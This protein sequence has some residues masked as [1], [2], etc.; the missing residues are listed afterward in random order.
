MVNDNKC[1]KC[2]KIVEDDRKL[3]NTPKGFMCI[4]CWT[5]NDVSDYKKQ[6]KKRR[7]E[8]NEF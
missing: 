6:W 4:E 8:E 5:K 2:G 7:E 1:V 3:V